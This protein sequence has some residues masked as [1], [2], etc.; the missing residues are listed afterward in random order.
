MGVHAALAPG[1]E[2]QPY[3]S[4]AEWLTEHAGSGNYEQVVHAGGVMPRQVTDQFV[5]SG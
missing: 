5:T 3:G 1:P 4:D 2:G